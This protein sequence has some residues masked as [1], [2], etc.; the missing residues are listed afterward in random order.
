MQVAR[1]KYTHFRVRA[2]E[3]GVGQV[4]CEHNTKIKLIG[5]LSL[6]SKAKAIGGFTSGKKKTSFLCQFFSL[7]MK[8]KGA[9]SDHYC[10]GMQTKIRSI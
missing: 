1:V 5:L 6:D 3:L 10:S 7:L 4:N 8:W 2:T 9:E